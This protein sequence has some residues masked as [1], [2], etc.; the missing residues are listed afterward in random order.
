MENELGGN[1]IN[2]TIFELRGK[3]LLN[4]YGGFF[5]T[6]QFDFKSRRHRRRRFEMNIKL[7]RNAAAEK[8]DGGGGVG[9]AFPDPLNRVSPTRINYENACRFHVI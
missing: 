3:G 9:I 6:I 2:K 8:V 7:F 4:L 1:L 5:F